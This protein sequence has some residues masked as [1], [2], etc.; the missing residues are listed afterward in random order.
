MRICLISDEY[1]PETSNGG[2]GT[3]T[4]HLAHGLASQGNQVTVVS[5]A[6]GH[7]KDYFDQGVRVLRFRDQKV[8]FRGFTRLANLFS[9]GLFGYWWHS[10]SLFNNIKQLHAVRSFDVLEGPLWGGLCFCYN[11]SLGFPLIVRLQTTDFKSREIL[12]LSPRKTLEFIEKQS[13]QKA[14]LIASISNNIGQLVSKRYD[15]SDKKIIYSPLG[16]PV[17]KNPPIFKENSFKLL[18]VSRLERRKGTQ[19][20]IESLPEMLR[21]ND[22]ITVDIIGK[23]IPQAPKGQY[24][25][26]F[27]LSTVPLDLQKRVKFHGFV[28]DKKLETFYRNCDVFITPSRYESFGLVYLEA[29]SYGKPVIGTKVGGIPEIIKD[30]ENGLLVPVNNPKEITRAVLELFDDQDLR[31]RIGQQAYHTVR[32]S[33]S[34]GR[35]VEETLKVYSLAIK[36]YEKRQ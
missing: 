32:N 15:I 1:P 3:Y 36:K 25:H 30:R 2:I 6:T 27:F 12:G 7:E 20:F 29:M 21:S 19:E 10:R 9:G 11:N 31:K 26:D 23:D 5:R 35:M 13:L 28:E 14:D 4:Y 33:F 18:Y 34:I 24:F 8:P 16:I 22:R 17:V